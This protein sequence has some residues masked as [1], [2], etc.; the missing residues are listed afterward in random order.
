MVS[1]RVD[2]WF[3]R[4]GSDSIDGPTE[5]AGAMVDGD[6]LVGARQAGFDAGETL[7]LAD[8]GS[9]LEVSGDLV[10]TGPTGTNAM[11]L[12]LGLKP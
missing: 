11:G 7:K 1:G 3:L 8:S 4:A 10:F 5:D 6:I 12:M 9:L 2:V